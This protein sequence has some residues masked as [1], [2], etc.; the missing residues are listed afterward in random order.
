MMDHL[1]IGD[2]PSPK[3]GFF[4]DTRKFEPE[5]FFSLPSKY[6]FHNLESLVEKGVGDMRPEDAETFLQEWLWFSFLAQVTHQTVDSNEFKN[7]EQGLY[8]RNLNAKLQHWIAEDS[9]YKSERECP[10]PRLREIQATMAIGYARRFVVKHLSFEPNDTD[11]YPR[12]RDE[13]EL[14]NKRSLDNLEKIQPSLPLSIAI[15]GQTLMRISMYLRRQDELVELVDESWRRQVHGNNIWGYSKYTRDQ[16]KLNGWCPSEI[17]RIES[18]L[19]GPCEVLYASSFKPSDPENHDNCD[20]WT[21]KKPRQPIFGALH[22]HNC[23]QSCSV[24]SIQNQDNEVSR[25]IKLGLTPLITYDGRQ[26]HLLSV[27]LKHQDHLKFGCLSHSWGDSLV[28]LGRDARDGNNRTIFRCQLER[29]Q[30]DFNKII[31]KDT[32]DVPFW[33]DVLCLP[34]Q[35]QVKARAIDQLRDIYQNASATIVWDRYMIEHNGIRNNIHNNMRLRLGD[36]SRRLWTL[37]ETVLCRDIYIAFRDRYLSLRD[38]NDARRRAKAITHEYHHVWEAG[39]PFTK[40]IWRLTDLHRQDMSDDK[41]RVP[42]QDV[43]DDKSRNSQQDVSDDK[44]RVLQTWAAVQFHLV[45]RPQDE[46]VILAGLLNL[47]ASSIGQIGGAGGENAIAARRMVKLLEEID[48]ESKLG[49]PAGI[50]FLPPPMLQMENVPETRGYAWAPRTWLS[51]QAHPYPFYESV[52]QAALQC[53]H[54]L[55]VRFPGVLLHCTGS[56]PAKKKFW[57]P[58]GQSMHEWLKIDV[59]TDKEW[60]QFWQEQVMHGEDKKHATIILSC[61]RL[62]DKWDIG[63]L[64]TKKGEL[65][66]KQVRWVQHVCRVRVRL[67]TNPNTIQ[68]QVEIFRQRKRDAVFGTRIEEREWCIGGES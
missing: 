13:T 26:I 19:A 48:S 64:V 10:Y 36:W 55:L 8:T 25:I 54:G 68:E 60:V 5:D 66:N 32:G 23:H 39:Y 24:L 53:K 61:P 18:T 41:S 62:R 45:E 65:R 34:R 28:D 15:L 56:C 43:S 6:G 9:H 14:A 12:V 58:L 50:I 44:S 21:C 59:Q 57:V 42:R 1:P 20:I 7:S 37:L 11:T 30:Q 4:A 35:E 22:M 27:D 33:V 63:I 17:R 52:H 51:K 2:M 16:M 38:I 47:N 49:I 46:A 31:K 3:T 29:M 40:A 67:E